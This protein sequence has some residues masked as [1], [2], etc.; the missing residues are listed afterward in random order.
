MIA[1]LAA[2][3]LLAAPSADP[4]I[5]LVKQFVEKECAA[6]VSVAISAKNRWWICQAGYANVEKKLP[7]KK[8]TLFRLGSVSK[9]IAATLAMSLVQEGQLNLDK[10][11]GAY[12]AGFPDHNGTITLRRLL[13]HTSGIRHYIKDKSDVFYEPKTMTEAL[14][15]F[16]DDPLQF[17]P[18]EKYS[19]STHAYTVIAAA[20]ESAS[21]M[22]YRDYLRTYISKRCAP[23]LDCE[24][25]ADNKADRTELYAKGSPDPKLQEKRQDISWKVGGGGLEATA[26]DIARFGY[27]V[28][29]RR[30]LKRETL[31]DMWSK[32]KQND[33]KLMGTGLGWDLSKKGFARHAGGQQGCS[34]Y[35]LVDQKKKIAVAVLCNTEG[36]P[37]GKLAEDLY[38]EYTK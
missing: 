1:A 3:C 4:K 24:V 28:A 7:V 35:L 18:G 32:Q 16:K 15:I 25:I 17:E 23:S 34:A 36:M 9:P 11:I 38:S 6:G 27:W 31:D 33:G 8:E 21:K 10:G 12:V 30:L 2:Y 20:V 26:E 14:G 5:D 13:C 19:Y 22:S 29:D 37:V